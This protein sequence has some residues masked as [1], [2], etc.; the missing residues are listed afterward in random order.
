LERYDIPSLDA[1]SILER[2]PVSVDGYP[3]QGT[4]SNILNRRCSIRSCSIKV[5]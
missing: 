3:E 2:V 1:T 4:K 5:V